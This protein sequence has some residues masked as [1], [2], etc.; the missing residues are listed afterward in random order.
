MQISASD[1]GN[2]KQLC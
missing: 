2:T 1:S